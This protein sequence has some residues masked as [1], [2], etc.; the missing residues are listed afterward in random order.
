M[1]DVRVVRARRFHTMEPGFPTAEAVAVRGDRI[2]AVGSFDAVVAA[3]GDAPF[4]VDG[5]GRALEGGGWNV[6]DGVAEQM[7]PCK[8]A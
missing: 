8:A 2:L 3:L 5:A 1:S 7:R 6:A 4:E